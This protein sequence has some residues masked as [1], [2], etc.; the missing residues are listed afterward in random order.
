M[1]YNVLIWPFWGRRPRKIAY[2]AYA[3]LVNETPQTAYFFSDW[4]QARATGTLC[5]GTFWALRTFMRSCLRAEIGCRR[6]I[7]DVMAITT[8][9]R[10]F[11]DWI[12]LY[13]CRNCGC[14]CWYCSLMLIDVKWCGLQTIKLHSNSRWPAIH[15]IIT[16]I[17]RS[18]SPPI[19]FRFLRLLTRL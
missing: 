11:I 4:L 13:S 14:W 6:K 19:C 2:N 1:T 3:C 7:V 18:L 5:E 9:R 8:A 10:L 12:M 17:A 15:A 16:V